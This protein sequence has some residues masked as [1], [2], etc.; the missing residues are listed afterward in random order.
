[1]KRVEISKKGLY[2]N[3][4]VD[5]KTKQL[6]M[7]G[8]INT[9][10]TFFGANPTPH[11]RTEKVNLFFYKEDENMSIFKKRLVPLI[12]VICAFICF[13]VLGLTLMLKPE[14]TFAETTASTPTVTNVED[15]YKNNVKMYVGVCASG[16]S[17]LQVSASSMDVE[18]VTSNG[19]YKGYVSTKTA[20]EDTAHNSKNTYAG[21]LS[22]LTYSGANTSAK[23]ETTFGIYEDNADN[24]IA[25]RTVYMGK[26]INLIGRLGGTTY[27]GSAGGVGGYNFAVSSSSVSLIALKGGSVAANTDMLSGAVSY[28]DSKTLVSGD[29]LLITYGA[30]GTNYYLKI[31]RYKDNALETIIDK[32]STPLTST[33]E[34]H[35][36]YT[37]DYM[38]ITS[39]FNTPLVIGGVEKPIMADLSSADDVTIDGEKT[40]GTAISEITLPQGY[41]YVDGTKTVAKGWNEFDVVAGN[42]YEK[43]FIKSAYILGAGE[44]VKNVETST[45]M[46]YSRNKS[47]GSHTIYNLGFNKQFTP[48]GQPYSIYVSNMRA[49]D[50]SIYS[51]STFAGNITINAIDETNSS[52]KMHAFVDR[53]DNADSILAFRTKWLGANIS[54]IGRMTDTMWYT[55]GFGGYQFDVTATAVTLKMCRLTAGSLAEKVVGTYPL[56]SALSTNDELIITYGATTN[57][58]VNSLYIKIEKVVDGNVTKL[59][60]KFDTPI[61]YKGTIPHSTE[62]GGLNFMYVACPGTTPLVIGGVDK[63]LVDA[64]VNHVSSA[65]AVVGEKV[66]TVALEAGY[67]ITNQD[68]VIRA[69][70]MAYAGTY[71]ADYYG[72]G[73]KTFAA[74]IS[75]IPTGAEQIVPIKAEDTD[76]APYLGMGSGNDGMGYG[77]NIKLDQATTNGLYATIKSSS[78]SNS[79]SKY[80]GNLT[81]SNK[82]TT[83]YHGVTFRNSENTSSVNDVVSFRTVYTGAD[84]YLLQM[85]DTTWAYPGINTLGGYMFTI[86]ADSFTLIKCT[87]DTVIASGAFDGTLSVNDEIVITFGNKEIE[88]VTPTAEDAGYFVY[89]YYLKVEKYGSADP[90]VD[91]VISSDVQI[92][93]RAGDATKLMRLYATV[94]KDSKLLIGGIDKPIFSADLDLG[95]Q[96]K[97]NE[98]LENVDLSSYPDYSWKDDSTELIVGE[99]SYQAILNYY[100]KNVDVNITVTATAVA[101]KEIT[102]I[103]NG[104]SN[105]YIV[106]ENK[107][108]VLEDLTTDGKMFIGWLGSDEKIYNA[109]YVIEYAAATDGMTFTLLQLTFNLEDGAS[110]R[111]GKDETGDYGM[112]FVL[113]VDTEKAAEYLSAGYI[114][115]LSYAIA[116]TDTYFTEGKFDGTTSVA[117]TLLLENAEISTNKVAFSIS[118]IQYQNFAR[119]FGGVAFFTVNYANGGEK[120]LMT[121]FDATKNSRSVYEV[122]MS[123]LSKMYAYELTAEDS[124]NVAILEGYLNQVADVTITENE[125]DLSVNLTTTYERS[126]AEIPYSIVANVTDNGDSYTVALE[127]EFDEGNGLGHEGTFAT[128]SNVGTKEEPALGWIVPVIVRANGKVY[129][130]AP[131]DGVVQFVSVSPY[132]DNKIVMT[133]KYTPANAN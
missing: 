18:K 54:L 61:M 68:A 53:Q 89:D 125:G 58:E 15:Y 46:G 128:Q 90:L 14:Q 110:I 97:Q 92:V 56:T 62:Y 71:T 28:D 50:D 29:E 43:Q 59:L 96:G 41:K 57:G 12:A 72:K 78:D 17:M 83:A 93:W 45:T 48:S 36:N 116:P 5:G 23:P 60:N 2:A 131:T 130:V 98:T 4:Q 24:V 64:S 19:N 6:T 95:E 7:T 11:Q 27:A 39:A 85:L 107:P 133:F 25:F 42:Y 101:Y 30:V 22:V 37:V 109:E 76:L 102:L 55:D 66:S 79:I 88:S 86:T 65:S 108:Y 73:N 94:G 106:Y 118:S 31:Q 99:K 33:F 32:F 75:L 8:S 132:A 49:E 113:N 10:L 122:S 35:N 80:A 91:K 115:N 63:P 112:R 120:V 119:E 3:A 117:K 111:Y 9:A 82:G 38:W 47:G 87:D 34:L 129:E 124:D 70:E 52:N 77:N 67:A 104:Q 26:N 121:A 100:G 81:L 74:N 40:V 51:K 44:T 103:V 1:M 16:G 126:E 114:T 105:N 84:I 21:N 123:L 127:I 69:G 20:T 13:T